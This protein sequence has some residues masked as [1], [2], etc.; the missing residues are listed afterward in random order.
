MTGFSWV[1]QDVYKKIFSCLPDPF[2]MRFV[3]GAVRN[4]LL[5][6]PFDDVDFATSYRP[7]EIVGFFQAH[8]YKVIPTG[9]EP[10]RYA[11]V[12]GEQL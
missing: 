2:C 4:T 10:H 12:Q 9:I 7:E 1:H 8:G 3:G 11:V 6:I 5:G